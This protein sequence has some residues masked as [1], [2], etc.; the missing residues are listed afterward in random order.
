MNKKQWNAFGWVF[1]I[2]SVYFF[3]WKIMDDMAIMKFAQTTFTDVLWAGVP[4]GM[5]CIILFGLSIVFFRCGRLE[6][7]Q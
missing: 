1:G 3:V 5:I 6:K 2:L 4:Q 7:K